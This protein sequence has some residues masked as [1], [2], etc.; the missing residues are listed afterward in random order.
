[1][2]IRKEPFFCCNKDATCQGLEGRRTETLSNFFSYLLALF[3]T[4]L[5]NLPLIDPFTHTPRTHFHVKC[6]VPWVQAL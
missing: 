4:A 1:M 3:Y 6:Q 2:Y 5:Y